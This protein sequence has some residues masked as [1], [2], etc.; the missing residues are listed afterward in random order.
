M[1]H[2]NG[3]LAA[4]GTRFAKRDAASW[5]PPPLKDAF[6]SGLAWR[7]T[8]LVIGPGVLYARD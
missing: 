5:Q 1:Q 4:D 7:G 8:R 6:G 2:Q 3:L